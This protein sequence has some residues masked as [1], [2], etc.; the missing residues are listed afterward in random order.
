MTSQHAIGRIGSKQEQND[1]CDDRGEC[2]CEED[3]P[4]RCR[5]TEDTG[6]D[7]AAG[8][9]ESNV[10]RPNGIRDDDR[11]NEARG[12]ESIIESLIRGES[13]RHFEKIGWKCR[14]GLPSQRFGPHE[15]FEP[16]NI[17]VFNSQQCDEYLRECVHISS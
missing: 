6:R 7:D 2:L 9:E 3:L 13:L 15:H 11:P 14:E 4:H 10:L 8:K 1:Q 12:E 5:S 16:E 17:D